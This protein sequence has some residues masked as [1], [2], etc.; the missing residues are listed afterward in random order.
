MSVSSAV[1]CAGVA[2]AGAL[3]A[4]VVEAVVGEAVVGEAVVCEFV[5]DG[6]LV[7]RG[8]VLQALSSIAASGLKMT[9]VRCILRRL[10]FAR[11]PETAFTTLAVLE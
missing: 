3:E 11:A 1:S 8:D 4:A 2:C 9:S 10:F 5:T 6:E 7:E